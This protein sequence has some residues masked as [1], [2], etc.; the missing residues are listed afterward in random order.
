MPRMD[1][2][3]KCLGDMFFIKCRM[4]KELVRKHLFKKKKGSKRVNLA[5]FLSAPLFIL[6]V[7]LDVSKNCLGGAGN[8]HTRERSFTL[9][10]ASFP[11]SIKTNVK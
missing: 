6:F 5:Y 8:Q 3:P 9:Q 1:T 10:R 2:Y 11:V 4:A 7:G